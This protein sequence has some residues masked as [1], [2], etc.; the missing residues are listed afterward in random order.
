MTNKFFN[1]LLM[2]LIVGV[3]GCKE[4]FEPDLPSVPQGYLVVE[5][6]INAGGTSPVTAGYQEKF[7][8]YFDQSPV[9]TTGGGGGGGGGNQG[10]AGGTRRGGPGERDVV[11][12][13]PP[14]EPKKVEGDVD[15][16]G[17]GGGPSGQTPP[18]VLLRF[19]PENELLIS[20]M[21]DGGEELAGR[22]AL[23]DCKV[24]KGH[25]LL[26]GINPMWRMQT[27]GSYMLMFNAIMTW[28]DMD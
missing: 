24:G 27:H 5:G 15:Q 18:K 22:A 28:N 1:I 9:L 6:F 19:A 16:Q 25:V 10:A 17:F 7:G 11:Q 3:M 21:L 20:G 2:A 12:G 14:Y 26:F 4:P 23:V 8:V 13:R